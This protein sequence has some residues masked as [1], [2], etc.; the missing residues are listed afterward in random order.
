MASYQVLVR[1]KSGLPRGYFLF[2][3]TPQVT[4]APEQK[5]FQNVYL[6]A[7]PV[8][9]R[10]GTVNFKVLKDFY[11]VTGTSSS[12]LDSNVSVYT[13]DYEV[14]KLCQKKGGITTNG[15]ECHMTGASGAQFVTNLLSETCTT[16]GS[17]SIHTDSSFKYP[18][19]GENLSTSEHEI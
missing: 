16:E 18:N 7:K 15:S 4:N 5:V 11:A 6:A 1:N 3:E 8:P 9:D 12:A 10:T 2:V 13:G 19:S 14:V 17:F